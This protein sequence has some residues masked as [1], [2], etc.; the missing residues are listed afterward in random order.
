MYIHIYIYTHIH[1]YIYIYIYIRAALRT[2]DVRCHRALSRVPGNEKWRRLAW[3]PR[4]VGGEPI[5]VTRYSVLR[6]RLPGKIAPTASLGEVISFPTI[7]ILITP[8]EANI[9][10]GLRLAALPARVG[11]GRRGQPQRSI[12]TT[13]ACLDAGGSVHAQVVLK[14]AARGPMVRSY[15]CGRM[16]YLWA[17]S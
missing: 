9:V 3:G 17:T 10:T 11:A 6:I 16:S 14:F 2:T 4:G 13:L 7:T 12:L 15:V 1:T 8:L 5:L